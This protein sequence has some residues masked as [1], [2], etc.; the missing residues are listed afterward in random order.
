MFN[1][2]NRRYL[3][4]KFKLLSF[5]EEVVNKHCKESQSFTDLFGGTGV[6]AH[7]FN[8]RFDIKVNDLLL[9]NY[10]SYL[11]FLGSQSVDTQKIKTKIDYYN[12]I[13]PSAKDNY[14]S[15]NFANTFL[16]RDNMWVVGEIRDNIE[17]EIKAG[18]INEREKAILVTSLIYSIDKIANTVGHY[19]AYRRNGELDRPLKIKFPNLDD[20]HNQKN[21]I[22]NLDSNQL[23]QEIESDI[24]YIDPPYNSRQYCDS[25]HFLENV[26]GN[27]KPEVVGVARK[28]DRS[29]LK[30]NYC[31]N[32]AEAEFRK[33]IEGIKAKYIIVSYN[34][35]SNKINS[36]SNAKIG[37][38]EILEILS[39][40]GKVYI[41]EKE[42]NAFTTGKTAL[43]NHKERL[44][45][46][47]VGKLTNPVN[48]DEEYS[49]SKCSNSKEDSTLPLIQSPLNY[50]GGKFRLLPQILPLL[51]KNIDSFYDV[52]SGGGNVG[53]NVNAKRIHAIDTNK[54][55]ISLIQYLQ[56]SDKLE[57]EK[58]IESQIDYYGLSNSFKNGYNFYNCDSSKGLGRF[59]KE[60][61]LKIR[62]DFNENKDHLKFLILIMYA[63]NNQI[64]FNLKQEFNLPVGKR[65][66]N[67]SM[68]KK[69]RN[70]VDRLKQINIKFECMDFRNLNI[71]NLKKENAFLYLDPPYILGLA[72]YNEGNGWFEEDEKD[73][74]DF[75]SLCDENNIRF[76]LSNVIRHKGNNHQ[77]LLDWSLSNSF[78]INHLK[79]NY[80]NSSYQTKSKKSET[81]EV[82]ITNY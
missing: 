35:T 47:E 38:N 52:F 73:L 8:D 71:E 3:G 10:L 78:N 56:K 51:P 19:D 4:S 31:T 11:T 57:L 50:T 25:Y 82:L 12:T 53:I 42:F 27:L 58:K 54:Y 7:H 65:D 28:M 20:S 23:V 69:L 1:I 72:S 76:A 68:R 43:S 40:R 70:F 30:S 22:Y 79:Y 34:N 66:F 63:F 14:Y 61:F 24:V 36:R 44:F 21:K 2:N 64:R 77:V 18:K 13:K 41:Y 32:K 75:L 5:I 81:Q 6:V 29:H 37:D 26:A 46:C 9:S 59:N 60:P 33:L 55:V 48:K 74:L 39:L 15:K 49:G 67:L 62:S 45:V 80:S 16:S 17:H